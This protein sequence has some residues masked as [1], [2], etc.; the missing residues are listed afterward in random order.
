MTAKAPMIEV[1]AATAAT[2]EARAAARALSVSRL[3]A[4]MTALQDRPIVIASEDLAE[5]DRQWAAIKTGQPTVLH[6]D[7]ERWLRTW[8]RPGFRK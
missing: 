7:V 4:E 2:L 6:E 1:G 3:A 5:L 8:G